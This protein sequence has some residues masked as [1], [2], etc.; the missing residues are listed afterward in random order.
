M[1][2]VRDLNVFLEKKQI[3]KT[4]V[5]NVLSIIKQEEG[6]KAVFNEFWKNILNTACNNNIFNFIEFNSL[7]DNARFSKKDV[8]DFID[9]E[10]S[11]KKE[12]MIVNII[13]IK[14]EILGK[15]CNNIKL[16][17]LLVDAL[18]GGD[19]NDSCFLENWKNICREVIEVENQTRQTNINYSNSIDEIHFSIFDNLQED[20]EYYAEQKVALGVVANN[21]D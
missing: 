13:D 10:Y 15:K 6:E 17:L 8:K 21:Y 2:L 18:W 16:D 11:G 5:D 14:E 4:D 19:P 12:E 7:I 3:H 1:S 20:T 9:I